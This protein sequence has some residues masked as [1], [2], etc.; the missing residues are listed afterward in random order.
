MCIRDSCYNT[1]SHAFI[2]AGV[3]MFI[4]FFMSTQYVR[5]TTDSGSS[6]SNSSIVRERN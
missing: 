2:Y 5:H 3:C 6:H 1:G 4:P